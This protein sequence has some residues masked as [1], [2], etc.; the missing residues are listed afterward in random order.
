MENK[1]SYE[2]IRVE[3]KDYILAVK[4]LTNII[5][6]LNG[7]YQHYSPEYKDFLR[8]NPLILLLNKE[9]DNILKKSDEINQ[10]VI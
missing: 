1:Q 4:E 9:R 6:I 5:D 7:Y 3:V 10:I 8:M 2:S